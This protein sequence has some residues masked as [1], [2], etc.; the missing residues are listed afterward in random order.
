MFV[1]KPVKE[2][3][4]DFKTVQAGAALHLM[5]VSALKHA[6]TALLHLSPLPTIH[7]HQ[8]RVGGGRFKM[9][10]ANDKLK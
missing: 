2:L 9:T 7:S 1:K 3:L 10:I 6:N 8:S 4:G 5:Q